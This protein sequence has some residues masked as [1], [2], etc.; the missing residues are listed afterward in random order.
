M[1]I[2]KLKEPGDFPGDSVVK[3]PPSKAGEAGSISGQGA[4]IPDATGRAKKK[5]NQG[6]NCFL[7][8]RFPGTAQICPVLELPFVPEDDV[9]SMILINSILL[10]LDPS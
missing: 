9:R 7:V 6:S 4:K 5:T 10:P 1:T 2:I 8:S 3:N